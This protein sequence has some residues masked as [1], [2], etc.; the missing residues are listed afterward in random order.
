MTPTPPRQLVN[1]DGQVI[2]GAAFTDWIGEY[3]KGQPGLELSEALADCIGATQLH[4]KASTF[5]LK[6]TMAPGEGFYGELLV[7]TQV[8]SAPARASAPVATFFPTPT[9]GLSRRDPNQ[10]QLP[11]TEQP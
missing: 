3:P 5:S 10:A 7:K 6:V 4:G 1:A 11:G 9:G 2:D 8:T